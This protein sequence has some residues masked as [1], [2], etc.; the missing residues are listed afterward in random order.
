MVSKLRCELKADTTL[1]ERT[2]L[3]G[4][5]AISTRLQMIPIQMYREDCLWKFNMDQG[6][7]ET[8]PTAC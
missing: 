2:L 8:F 7:F 3:K 4:D 6:Q 5:R 1:A